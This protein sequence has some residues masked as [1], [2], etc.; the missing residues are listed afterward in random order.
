M[1][2]IRRNLV[3]EPRRF[4]IS[5]GDS[6]DNPIVIYDDMTDTPRNL[7]SNDSHC[8][9][10]AFDE[11]HQIDSLLRRSS[12]LGGGATVM[13]HL[14]SDRH[15]VS[16]PRVTGCRQLYEFLSLLTHVWDLTLI[17]LGMVC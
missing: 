13:N 1:S 2:D 9:C 8:P 11:L 15:A 12:A 5:I 6:R 17:M 7:R 4:S 3:R 10:C 14:G 16:A